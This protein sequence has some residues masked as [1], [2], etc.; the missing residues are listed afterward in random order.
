[1]IQSRHQNTRMADTKAL[2]EVALDD[3]QYAFKQNRG[4]CIRHCAQSQMRSRQRYTHPTASQHHYYLRSM[5]SFGEKFGVSGK[6]NP[7]IVNDSLVYRCGDHAAKLAR[8]ATLQ[9]TAQQIE[10]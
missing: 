8:L 9:R 7:C 3:A 4:D 5:R 6:R 1:R 2:H 10:Y